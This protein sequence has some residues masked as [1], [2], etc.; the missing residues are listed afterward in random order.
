VQPS[1]EYSHVID[2]TERPLKCPVQTAEFKSGTNVAVPDTEGKLA[3]M[4]TI[5]KRRALD[6]VEITDILVNNKDANAKWQVS[7]RPSK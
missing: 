5:A 3:A 2:V 1:F 7:D 6:M 4:Q